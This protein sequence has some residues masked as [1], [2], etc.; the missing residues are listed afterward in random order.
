MNAIALLTDVI[1]TQD[2][3]KNATFAD[4]FATL[5]VE[6]LQDSYSPAAEPA[7]E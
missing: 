3:V 4:W 5:E 1:N 6:Q 2:I 7:A